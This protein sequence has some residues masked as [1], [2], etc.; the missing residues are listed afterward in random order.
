MNDSPPT[1][2]TATFTPPG[3][4][5]PLGYLELAGRTMGFWLELQQGLWQSW[6][7]VQGP[8]LVYLESQ[9]GWPGFLP[10]GT[11]QLG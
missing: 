3:L 8:W 6:L 9:S 11:E 5:L 1:S 10:R 7:D 2:L 4:D